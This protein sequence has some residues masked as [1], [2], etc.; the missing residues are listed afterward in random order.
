[1]REA[2]GYPPFGRLARVV[3][4]GADLKAVRAAASTIAEAI[5]AVSPEDWRVLGPS[6]APLARVKR[7]YRWHS[8][9]KA[10]VGADIPGAL[11]EALSRAG[12]FEGVSV[13]PDVDPADLM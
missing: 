2:L 10:P 9:V 3:T 1:M 4:S 12:S 6:P 11:W 13:A 5:R 8:L 7:S